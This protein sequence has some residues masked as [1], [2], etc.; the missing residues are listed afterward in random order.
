MALKFKCK[1][2]EEVPAELQSLYVERDGAFVLDVDGAVD[3]ARVDEFRA[4]NITLANQ[5]KPV[6]EKSIPQGD[7]E[8]HGANEVDENGPGACRKIARV[9]LVDGPEQGKKPRNLT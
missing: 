3:E 8:P 7:V 6:R 5:N 2:K 4:N 9:R 1:S